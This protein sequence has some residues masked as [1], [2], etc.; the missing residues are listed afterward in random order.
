MGYG[1]Y[2]ICIV[3]N[4][5]NVLSRGTASRLQ[6]VHH[7]KPLGTPHNGSD[8][9]NNMICVCPNCHIQL[10]LGA[11][12]LN[13]ELLNIISHDINDDNLNYYQTRIFG[14]NLNN[15]LPI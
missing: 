8:N 10:D 15:R 12:S 6:G 11:I 5:L 3:Q 1:F 2:A 9:K 13:R 14:V 7:I 4:Y